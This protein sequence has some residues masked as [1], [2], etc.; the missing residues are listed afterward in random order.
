MVNQNI[1]CPYCHK[2]IPLTEAITHSIRE[3]IQKEFEKE[4]LSKNEELSRRERLL[5]EKEKSISEEISKRLSNERARLEA[6]TKKRF[7]EAMNLRLREFEEQIKQRDQMLEE[8]RKVELQLRKE[9][10]ELEER[11]KSLELEVARRLDEERERIRKEAESRVAEEHRLKDLEK[12]KR[13]ND[14][15]R[16]IEELKRRAEQGP[17]QTRG[18]VLETELEEI[19]R[20]QFPID[21]IEPVPRGKKGADVLQR[22]HNQLGQFCGTIIWE[23]KRTKNWNDGWIDKLKEDQREAKAEIAVIV[24]TAM[25]KDVVN[26]HLIDGVWVTEYNLVPCL[27]MALRMNLIQVASERRAAVGKQEKMEALYSYLSGPE[28][29]QKVEAIV[30]AFLSMKSDLE[31]EKAAMSRIWAKREKQIERVITNITRMYGDM[32]G[33][34]GAS[35]PEIKSIEFKNLIDSDDPEPF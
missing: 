19:L 26:F 28:F 30:K 1:I 34:I 15:L 16:D 29:S 25:P 9:R 32:Q 22:V 13:I 27:A 2:E 14:L 3:E 10:R 17:I 4:L 18:E 35:L 8:M 12:D 21:Q 31:S 7:E 33:I 11:Q 23:A 24:T 5:M 6:E 20:S